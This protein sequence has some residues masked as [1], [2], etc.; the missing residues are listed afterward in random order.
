MK[1]VDVSKKKQSDSLQIKLL[2]P[3]LAESLKSVQSFGV[4]HFLFSTACV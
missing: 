3:P 4:Q 2:A 1:G